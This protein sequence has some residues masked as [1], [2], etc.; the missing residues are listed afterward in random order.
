KWELNPGR[1]QISANNP[2]HE[3]A[4]EIVSVAYQG[5]PVEVSFN[6]GYLLDAISAIDSEKV[7]WSFSNLDDGVL[8]EPL[9]QSDLSLFVVMP[10]LIP[11]IEQ[12]KA[13]N[14]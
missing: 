3:E 14:E 11:S 2:E 9:D 13:V 7:C 5:R 8:I 6:V 10:L 12:V 4:E 1:L